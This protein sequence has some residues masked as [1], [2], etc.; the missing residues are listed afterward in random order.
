[1]ELDFA[2]VDRD[3]LFSL[4]PPQQY[5]NLVEMRDK[6]FASNRQVLRS[7]T[8]HEAFGRRVVVVKNP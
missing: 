8:G 6:Q 1:V 2:T 3:W 4:P 7:V 5:K